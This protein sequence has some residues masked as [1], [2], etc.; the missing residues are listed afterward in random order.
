[1]FDLPFEDDLDKK[2]YSKFKK[3]IIKIGYT[4]MQY[5]IYVRSIN[6]QSKINQEIDKVKKI[7]PERGNIRI[8]VV[9]EKQYE[10]MTILRGKKSL[11]E[12]YN[13]ERRYLKI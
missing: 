7:L 8:I 13:D 12:I 6:T 2:I 9:T 11:N 3:S 10:S 1:M 5:S 4:M